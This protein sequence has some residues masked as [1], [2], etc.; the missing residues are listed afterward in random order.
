MYL[1]SHSNL[2]NINNQHANN[3]QS[4]NKMAAWSAEKK[5]DSLVTAN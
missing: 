2:S 5:I 3:F 4:T 1:K